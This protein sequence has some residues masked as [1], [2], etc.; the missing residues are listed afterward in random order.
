MMSNGEPLDI[1]DLSD[2]ALLSVVVQRFLATRAEHP[3]DGIL[4]STLVSALSTLETRAA[5]RRRQEVNN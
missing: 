1:S 4:L 2:E 3:E 5:H